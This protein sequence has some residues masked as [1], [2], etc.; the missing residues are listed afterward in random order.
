M[1][2]C[3]TMIQKNRGPAARPA[4]IACSVPGG[5][6]PACCGRCFIWPSAW[7]PAHCLSGSCWR[8]NPDGII[9]IISF[10]RSAEASVW[11]GWLPQS[12]KAILTCG[13][14]CFRLKAAWP[15]LSVPSF[16]TQRRLWTSGNCL[17]WWMMT[18]GNTAGG[19]TGWPWE[20]DGFSATTCQPSS[21]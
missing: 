9:W 5:G 20:S 4:A 11:A 1:C 13:T 16:L 7:A 12:M 2:L 15:G 21:G 19:L 18:F 10:W 17:P 6:W 3:E 14:S 8:I